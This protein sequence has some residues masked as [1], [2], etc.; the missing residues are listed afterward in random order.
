[1]SLTESAPISFLDRNKRAIYI[2]GAGGH[3]RV[4]SDFF[5]PG[6][7]T[8]FVDDNGLEKSIL[9]AEIPEGAEVVVA[10]G[11][12]FAREKVFGQL[13]SSEKHLIFPVVKHSS[14]I[15][16]PRSFCA[17][18]SMFCATSIVIV[19]ARIGKGCIVNTGASI[20][21]DCV[22][23]DFVHIAPGTRLCG[24]VSVGSRT[25]IGV[26]SSVRPGIKI[27]ANTIIGAG[28]VVVSDI[29]SGVLAFGNP[30]RVVKER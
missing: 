24:T 3:G 2:Y 30:C 25:L 5:Y 13:Q 20:D 4:V 7:P 8:I 11:D 26:G 18:G 17:E 6:R 1:M 16:S 12:N 14:A 15:I 28:S 19:G 23:G 22:L 21:H 29:P 9:P 27:G 10:I